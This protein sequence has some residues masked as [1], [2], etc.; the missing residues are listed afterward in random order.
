[1]GEGFNESNTLFLSIFPDN[2]EQCPRFGW[3]QELEIPLA[4]PP[5]KQDVK[6]SHGKTEVY[7]YATQF[8]ATYKG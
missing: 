6:L 7:A 2:Q 4:W 8:R 3:T 1:M 5:A